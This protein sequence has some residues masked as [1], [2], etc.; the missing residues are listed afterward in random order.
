[1]FFFIWITLSILC[2][3]YAKS[4]VRSGLGFFFLENTVMMN[5]KDA[6]NY[7]KQK[8]KPFPNG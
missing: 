3:L 8:A 5:L 2:G 1:M 4:K 6:V 7:A